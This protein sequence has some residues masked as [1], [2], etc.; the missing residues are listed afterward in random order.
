MFSSALK[1]FTSNISSNYSLSPHPTSYSGP[2]K[3]YDAKK[4]STGKAA[5]VFVFE[6]KSLEPQGGASLGG[7]ANA[8]ALKRAHEEVV[9]RLKKEASSLARLRHPSIL[10]LAEPV[11]ETRGGG[12]MFATE[13][14]TASLAGLL[15][16]KDEQEKAGGVG[17][18]RSRYVVE[19]SDGQKRRRELEIDELEI[20]K[21]LLQIAKGLEFLHESAGL[22]HANMTPEAIFVNAK[23]DWKISGLGFSSP[24]ENSTKPT[25]ATPIALSEVLHYDPRLPRH[26]QLNL[27]YSSPDFVVDGNVTPAADMFSLGLL[28][29]A[30]YNSPHRSPLEF[31]GSQS[32]YKRAFSSSSSVPTK[33]NNFMSSQ[34][35]PKDVTNGVLDRLI[36]RRPAQRLDA[37]EFQQAQYFD[38]ILVST[39]RFLDSLPAKTPNEKSQFMRG[40]PRIL[41]QFPKS[42]LEKKVLPALLEEMKDREL[43]ALVLQNVFKIITT[44]TSGKRAFTE[45]V[46]PRLRE[47]FLSGPPT[48]KGA[49]APER[50]SLKEA[51][52][53][54]LL[55]NMA[56][57]VENSSGK[58]FKDNI[59]PILQHA[60]E[61]P[62]HSV[63]DAALRTLPFVLPI[64]DFSTI[65]N[66]LFPVIATVFAKTSSMGIKIRGLEALKTL[67]G[68]GPEEQEIQGDGLTGVV[69]T[70]KPSSN[71]SI[72]DKYTI[73]EKVVPLLKGIKTK[74]PAVM[75]AA[76]DVFKAIGSQVD[77]DFLAMDI[78]PILWQFSLG[79]LLNLPQFQAYMALIKSL[80]SRVENEQTRKLQELGA[81]NA[82]VSTSR[83]EFMSFGGVGGT[84]GTDATNGDGEAGFE[85]LV[86]GGNANTS[87]G[88]DMLGGDSWANAPASA[89]PSSVLPSRPSA[90]R[91][92]S[93]NNASPAATFSWSTPPPP[94]SPPTNLSAPQGGASRTITPDNTLSS[95]NSSFPALTPLNPS[96]SNIGSFSPPQQARPSMGMSMNSMS[97]INTNLSTP[98][99]T[100]QSSSLDWSKATAPAFNPWGNTGTNS[101]TTGLSNFSI[102]PPPSQPQQQSNVYSG[103]SIAPPPA[104]GSNT[105][106][107]APPPRTGAQTGDMSTLGGS[108]IAMS[109]RMAQNQNQQR[110]V[111]LQQTQQTQ[112]WGGGSDSLI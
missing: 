30:L 91:G 87:S 50:D 56:I 6:K 79:P 5:S 94:M 18:R 105:F 98:T 66:E 58:E 28:I 57:A 20:Q 103:F 72:L 37:R 7:R 21:G 22:V 112:N 92:R 23:S 93:S 53:M 26:V 35:L 69:E 88:T 29:I 52:L 51:G 33:S 90:H 49:A 47:I 84:N 59:L 48:S 36:T 54:I 100:T 68:G 40:L 11:E 101:S 4:K 110:P 74:E 24:P 41:S 78:L 102:A 46:I 1:S 45:K 109:T 67:C 31:N 77:A 104:T 75:M 80:S 2:W 17:G 42:V 107:I 16:E 62:T 60:L 83:N 3:I 63:V 111:Q 12:L 9:E 81:S 10:E 43:L 44:L 34:P 96:I 71:V 99:Y 89:S 8:S 85:A 25:S 70:P 15:Q 65:K 32:S 38:N 27:D 76:L 86:R 13:P 14:V 95:L 108:G 82:T 97:S 61:S 55:E 73:Q 64:I 19:E 106:S 39:I